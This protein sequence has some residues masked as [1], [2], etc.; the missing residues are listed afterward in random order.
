MSMVNKFKPISI[1]LYNVNLHNTMTSCQ[2]LSSHSN[3]LF[4]AQFPNNYSFAASEEWSLYIN[5]S[6]WCIYTLLFLP[7]R[8]CPMTQT[9]QF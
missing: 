5:K 4:L 9:A 3:I 2:T 8:S 6:C 7:L 1:Y